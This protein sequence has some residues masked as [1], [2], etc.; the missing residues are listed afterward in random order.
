MPLETEVS[1][2]VLVGILD[3][4]ATFLA[5]RYSG[6]GRLRV[7]VVESNPV[8]RWVLHHW[9]VVGMAVFKLFMMGLVVTIAVGIER[10]RPRVARALLWGGVIV[11]AAVVIYSARLIL[12]HQ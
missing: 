5:L 9:G 6:E 11:V 12:L 2:F 3:I 1:W 8:A 7:N 4:V 10:Y